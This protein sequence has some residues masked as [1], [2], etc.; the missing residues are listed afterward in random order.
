MRYA[1]AL[2]AA[3]WLTGASAQIKPAMMLPQSVAPQAAG[4]S[5][6]HD[7]SGTAACDGTGSGTIT[8]NCTTLTI[9][10]GGSNYAL[11]VY[12][13]FA[14]V[15]VPSVATATW[16]GTSVP[17]VV[18]AV[19]PNN[20]AGVEMWCLAAPTS[21][22]QTLSITITATDLTEI[23][24]IAASYYNVNQTTPCAN[25]TSSTSATESL[26]GSIT[27]T[28]NVGDIAT[29]VFTQGQ[30]SEASMNG[31]VIVINDDAG[32]NVDFNANYIAGA[33][34]VNLTCTA[35]SGTPQWAI[36]AV[37]IQAVP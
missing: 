5:V 25:G 10:T 31:T 26:T 4:S 36:G 23:H 3:L 24:A 30:T 13:S 9:G 16:N 32:P 19:N 17:N 14:A 34:T 18:N 28:S 15:A 29:A 7:A 8:L 2:L 21:G 33:S 37:D 1:L 22:N 27:V 6:T 11:V 35:S 12:A 20:S